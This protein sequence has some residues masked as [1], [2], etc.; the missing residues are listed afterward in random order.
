M[1]VV[2]VVLDELFLPEGSGEEK[3]SLASPATVDGVAVSF[4]LVRGEIGELSSWP[5]EKF[6]AFEVSVLFPESNEEDVFLLS[7]KVDVP[8]ETPPLSEEGVVKEQF[9]LLLE[10]V[11]GIEDPSL[12]TGGAPL[13]AETC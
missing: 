12:P 3:T 2:D 10:A 4:L 8:L 7:L 5:P 1:T 11:D 13:L 6:V 9:L